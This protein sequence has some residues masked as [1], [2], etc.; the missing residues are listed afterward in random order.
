[1]PRRVPRKTIAEAIGPIV[2]TMIAIVALGFVLPLYLLAYGTISGAE[3]LG[4]LVI[5][6]A[7]VSL[8]I[9]F[10]VKRWATS[11]WKGELAAIK[12]KQLTLIVELLVAV[13]AIGGT[14]LALTSYLTPPYT[15][16]TCDKPANVNVTSPNCQEVKTV[17]IS[18][19]GPAGIGIIGY[20]IIQLGLTTLWTFVLVYFV[21][22]L[23]Q[24]LGRK[25]SNEPQ[26]L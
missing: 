22:L 20:W 1:M 21:V 15:L 12:G 18:S 16:S 10:W 19:P 4:W 9:W 26:V 17:T 24:K 25:F 23:I 2:V 5:A 6:A 7:V 14:L 8:L 13:F 11:L 3:F